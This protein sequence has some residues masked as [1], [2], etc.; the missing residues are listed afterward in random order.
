MPVEI[1]K[2]E[3]DKDDQLVIHVRGTGGLSAEATPGSVATPLVGTGSWLGSGAESAKSLIEH[4]ETR[5]DYRRGRG[6]D[7][8]A[9]AFQYCANQLRAAIGL[10]ERRQ[11]EP[12][13]TDEPHG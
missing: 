3:T 13:R 8:S 7:D 12:N 6:W 9:M 5:A 4:W 10:P 2:I 11:P 1:T